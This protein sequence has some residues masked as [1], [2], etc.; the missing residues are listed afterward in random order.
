MRTA[1]G[2]A[3]LAQGESSEP[4][5]L[6][7]VFVHGAFS[8]P[9]AWDA[10]E[11]LLREDSGLPANIRFRRFEYPTPKLKLAMSSIPTLDV[12]ADHLWSDA[13]QRAGDSPMFFVGHS[14]GG[15]IIT[16]LLHRRLQSDATGMNLRRV[17]GAVLFA[18]PNAGSSYGLT[19]RR[20]AWFW[21][22][23]QERQLRPLD[24]QVAE[25]Q[26]V[27]VQRLATVGTQK[28]LDVHIPVLAVAGES[29][30]VVTPA[31]A[32]GY[33]P[34]TDVAPG[35][36]SS[37]IQPESADSLAYL[38]L[39]ERLLAA[40][41]E[42]TPPPT[43][44][45][46]T[47]NPEAEQWRRLIDRLDGQLRLDEWDQRVGGLVRVPYRMRQSAREDLYGLIHWLQ[48]RIYPSGLPGLRASIETIGLVTR[49][50]L[51][52]F[53]EHASQVDQSDPMDPLL[54]V[55]R[56]YKSHG[57]N[58]RY[59]EEAEAYDAHVKLLTDLALELTRAVNWFSDEVR[60]SIDATYRL[61]DGLVQVEGGPYGDGDT[62]VMLPVY[63][64][65]E[66]R[67]QPRPYIDL[68]TYRQERYSRDLH[69]TSET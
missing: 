57:W 48:S 11:V 63:S 37:V 51:L 50:L 28:G 36:H 13:R 4:A 20:L 3:P 64:A 18:C 23:P 21:R 15:L 31:S 22:H 1:R 69:T 27:V 55:D 60:A 44:A 54:E 41:G 34:E 29:D 42:Q 66:R 35:D 19:L 7:V 17:R 24:P 56:W 2:G 9:Q 12:A 32:R 47:A 59:H 5:V 38:L 45:A 30:P 68:A 8:S 58:E 25:A 33:W 49:D 14:Q 39:R 53:D 6:T 61:D 46:A 26:R 43:H 16:R 10:F 67:A 62:L 65:S 40:V 52:T